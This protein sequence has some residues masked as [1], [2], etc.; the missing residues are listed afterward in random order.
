MSSTV[1]R[2]L[3]SIGDHSDTDDASGANSSTFGDQQTMQ[4]AFREWP[5]RVFC[6]V[7]VL[8]TLWFGFAIT[9][10]MRQL[11][12]SQGGKAV[13]DVRS[14]SMVSLSQELENALGVYRDSSKSRGQFANAVL[15]TF[16]TTDTL[17]LFY[18]LDCALKSRLKILAFTSEQSVM[19]TLRERGHLGYR[20]PRFDG[21]ASVSAAGLAEVLLRGFDVFYMDVGILLN[22]DPFKHVN[23]V[24]FDLLLLGNDAAMQSPSYNKAPDLD[25]SFM[26]VAATPAGT[27]MVEAWADANQRRDSIEEVL[28]QQL[29]KNQVEYVKPGSPQNAPQNNSKGRV[30]V[31]DVGKFGGST[32]Q[33]SAPVVSLRSWRS[34][35]EKIAYLRSE[36][37]WYLSETDNCISTPSLD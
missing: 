2:R 12:A 10:S 29:V 23:T 35:A 25:S 36:S 33:K 19:D 28:I 31:F 17:P 4:A 24:G 15:L 20:L 13:V 18:N 5:C 22:E 8:C 9:M 32:A 21:V 34:V 27:K 26:F 1:H 14:P 6:I 37:K 3:T 30:G 16:V 11:D 7:L